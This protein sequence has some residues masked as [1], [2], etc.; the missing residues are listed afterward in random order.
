MKRRTSIGCALTGIVF[1]VGLTGCG[2]QTPNTTNSSSPT[3]QQTVIAQQT[4][5]AHLQGATPRPNGFATVL[6][7]ETQVAQANG[8]ATVLAQET[9]QA[10]ATSTTEA[11]ATTTV[12]TVTP[13]NETTTGTIISP[14]SLVSYQIPDGWTKSTDIVQNVG[15]TE[16]VS[17]IVLSSN[18]HYEDIN[19]TID[20]W[21]KSVPAPL[22]NSHNQYKIVGTLCE[23]LG[24]GLTHDQNAIKTSRQYQ[25]P[26]YDGVAG[27]Q[28]G[29][30]AIVPQEVPNNG[31]ITDEDTSVIAYIDVVGNTAVYYKTS[32]VATETSRIQ[33]DSRNFYN[34]IKPLK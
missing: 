17:A 2:A 12:A 9:A 33:D 32:G 28:C 16:R 14:D 31:Y 23:S 5:I 8:F 26:Q 6:A 13:N 1:S 30:R 34:S 18:I 25:S 21:T 10:Q 19:E 27:S 20:I 4:I 24:N 15:Q 22:L 7:H 3:L 11:T 29:A